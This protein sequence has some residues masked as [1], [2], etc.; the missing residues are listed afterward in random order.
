[1]LCLYFDV[2]SPTELQ[3]HAGLWRQTE[4]GAKRSHD[5]K[6]LSEQ[7]WTVSV[8]IAQ[9]VIVTW[10]RRSDRTKIK[11]RKGEEEEGKRNM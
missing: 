7:C 1:M 10:G 4:S 8:N 6:K 2:K 11:Q 9:E 3:V 5:V